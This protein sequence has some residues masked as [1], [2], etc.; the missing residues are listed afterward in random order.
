M[1]LGCTLPDLVIGCDL[2]P[3]RRV[4][5]S[6]WWSDHQRVLIELALDDA[7]QSGGMLSAVV[8]VTSPGTLALEDAN[9]NQRDSLFGD[10]P[11]PPPLR[12]LSDD[13]RHAA[14]LIA[15]RHHAARAAAGAAID[16]LAG[17]LP[18]AQRI[19]LE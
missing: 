3:A 5:V 7:S 18:P 9:A 14:A 12:R 15:L 8:R 17:Q 6:K 2:D 4:A 13:P 16:L 19:R 1:Q 11:I 10:L